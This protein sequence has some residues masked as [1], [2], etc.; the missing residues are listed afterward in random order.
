MKF[1]TIACVIFLPIL[2]HCTEAVSEES[3]NELVKAKLRGHMLE[4]E[5][6][7]QVTLKTSS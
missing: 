4:G 3:S 7:F 6:I 5:N 1:V 2:V